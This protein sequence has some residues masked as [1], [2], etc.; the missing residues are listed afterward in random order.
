MQTAPKRLY[1]VFRLPGL[2]IKSAK[3]TNDCGR[4]SLRDG[5]Y[6]SMLLSEPQDAMIYCTYC[7]EYIEVNLSNRGPLLDLP[8]PAMY[9][10]WQARV[11]V[12][13]PRAT[14]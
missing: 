5:T 7:A 1:A 12:V 11:K 14:A 10:S 6:H 13:W 9:T 3:N 2:G 4:V 8:Q